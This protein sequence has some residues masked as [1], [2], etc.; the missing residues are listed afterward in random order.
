MISKKGGETYKGTP[1]RPAAPGTK[2]YSTIWCL[3]YKTSKLKK[4]K[5]KEK[6]GDIRPDKIGVRRTPKSSGGMPTAEHWWD[7]RT[8]TNTAA[9]YIS[10]N[11]RPK[12]GQHSGT[13][14]G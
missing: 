4:K 14:K 13:V 1:W 10:S 11:N 6:E 9:F 7:Q 3:C 12:R 5:K 2:V 8:W